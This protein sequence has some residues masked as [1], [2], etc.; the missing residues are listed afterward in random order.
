[1][2]GLEAGCRALVLRVLPLGAQSLQTGQPLRR[3]PPG[4]W[5]TLGAGRDTP[6][7]AWGLLAPPWGAGGAFWDEW[8]GWSRRQVPASGPHLG[9][10]PVASRVSSPALTWDVV[11]EVSMGSWPQLSPV[12]GGKGGKRDVGQP[13][14]V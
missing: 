1:M 10:G 13:R 5:H 14:L 6:A 2:L 9:D 11:A 3:E 8:G 12:H 7:Q 4:T